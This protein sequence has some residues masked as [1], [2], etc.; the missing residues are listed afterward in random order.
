[1]GFQR[2]L[3]AIDYSPLSQEVFTQA[4]DL[5]R[6]NNAK[7]MLFHCVS[8]ETMTGSSPFSGE[9]GLLPRIVNQAYQAQQIYLEQR[10]QD[11]Q[12]LL[13]GYCETA[14]Q[15]G[16]VAESS[17]QI[18]DAG[19]GL[20]QAAQSW[21][22]DLIVLGR[23]GRRGLTE[24]LLGSVSNYVLHHADCT[25]LIVQSSRSHPTS[26]P[27]SSASDVAHPSLKVDHHLTSH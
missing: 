9:L 20:C 16:V 23:R 11:I 15:Q 26:N 19:Q 2:I 21:Q 18:A 17:Y 8:E 1:M 7:L 27:A 3:A 10:M 12:S 25:V 4:L 24:V 14:A 6:S 5:A 22:A 13:R